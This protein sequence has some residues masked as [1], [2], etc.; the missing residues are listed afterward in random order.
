MSVTL[1][2]YGLICY[3][4]TTV[5]YVVNLLNM[6]FFIKA[7]NVE[8]LCSFNVTSLILLKLFIYFLKL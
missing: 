1:V 4:F 2:L 6:T 8:V 5:N 3:P 7:I